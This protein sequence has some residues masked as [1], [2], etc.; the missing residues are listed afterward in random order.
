MD[1]RIYKIAL[2]LLQGIGPIKTKTLVAYT[3]NVKTIFTS[4]AKELSKLSGLS[5]NKIQ[6]FKRE[7]A[8]QRAQEE[9]IFI[10]KNQI[11]IHYYKDSNYPV[12]S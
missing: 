3:G 10:R 1:D 4:S 5:I 7:E 12:S 6:K 2:S 11:S 8:I 9:L